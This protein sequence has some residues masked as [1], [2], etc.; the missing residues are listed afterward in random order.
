MVPDRLHEV[1]S[2]VF[3]MRPEH[4][5]SHEQVLQD[6]LDK[7]FSISPIFSIPFCCTKLFK[8]DWLHAVDL[9]VAA[10]FSGSLFTLCLKELPGRNQADQCKA[11]REL[12]QEFYREHK[13]TSRLDQLTPT[14][15]KKK[16]AKFP[17]LRAKAG[18][19]RELVPF[20][21]LIA[22][23]LLETPQNT[24][25]LSWPPILWS[26]ATSVLPNSTLPMLE[27]PQ[28][29]GTLHCSMSG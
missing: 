3:W 2:Q 13:C 18:E 20:A 4:R 7:G 23:R 22:H 26:S 6:I 17:K 28:L 9:G 1:D 19:A 14:M 16:K 12:M 8:I 24:W 15:L 11:L 27:L 29:P 5:L 25:Q 10:D 21:K